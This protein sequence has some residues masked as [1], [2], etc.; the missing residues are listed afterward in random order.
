MLQIAF[1]VLATAALI[2]AGLAVLYLR[3]SVA[4]H[5]HVALPLAHGALGVVG[6]GLLIAI[7]RHGLPQADNG[8]GGFGAV[9]AALFALAL[10]FGLLIAR[11]AWRGRR[12]GG[13]VVASHASLAIAGLV[14][15]LTLVALG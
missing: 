5:P 13:V 10:V 6:L 12:P 14:V 3:G 15:L 8:T 11:A 2:G 1:A 7:L 9:A 4:P